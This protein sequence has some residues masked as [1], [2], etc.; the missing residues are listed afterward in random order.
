MDASLRKYQ[1]LIRLLE[2]EHKRIG[3]FLQSDLTQKYQRL[4][5]E[6]KEMV[7]KQMR[8]FYKYF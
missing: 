5:E 4:L 7:Q 1:E 8:L 2:E 6:E 3:V